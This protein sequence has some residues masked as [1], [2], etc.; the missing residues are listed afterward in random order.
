M[1]KPTNVHPMAVVDPSAEL[2]HGVSV[3]PFAV[4]GPQV[5]VGAGTRIES[6]AQ[7][8]GPSTIGPENHIFP[9]AIVGFEPQ[10]LKFDGED[11]TLEIGARNKIR[12]LTTI[13]RG[14]SV[15]GGVTTVGD[16]N[17]FMTGT[18]IAHDCHVGSHTIFA[19][20]ATLAGHVRVYDHSTVGAFSSIHQ[21]CRVGR[22]AFI[23]GY[24]VITRD[25]LPFVKTVGTR[26]A[27]YG[28]NRIG[29]ERRG[30]DDA[31][32]KALEAAYRIL[33]RARHTPAKAVELL[34]ELPEHPELNYLIEFIGG[35][36]RGLI[37]SP[38][39]REGRRGQ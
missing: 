31:T 12:E 24:S 15:G 29:L 5:K 1:E 37:T 16:D 33:V 36:D 21:H 38:P 10:D 17:L 18:H 14:T 34:S 8:R 20:N 30:F 6:G 26:P 2:D 23:G 28:I 7:L 22:H 35:T 11:T 4:I 27:C 32:L 19:N 9:G 39:G 3:G 25:A 13:H